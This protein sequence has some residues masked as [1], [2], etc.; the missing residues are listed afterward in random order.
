MIRRFAFALVIF[1]LLALNPLKT[2]ANWVEVKSDNFTFIGDAS[3]RKA[4]K[5]VEEVE[6]YRA[7][8]FKM[9]G[10]DP[11]S[12]I[13]P[14]RIYATKSSREITDITG[15]ENAGGVYVPRRESPL[16]VLNIRGGFSDKSPAKSIALHEYTHHLISRHTNQMY[17]R[18]VNEGMAEYLSTFTATDSG[19][20]RIGLP[21]ETRGRTLATYQWM[22]WD[23]IFGSIRRYP[24]AND[25]SNNTEIGQALF[26]A[27]SW[28]AIH[29]IQS[30]PGLPAVLNTYIQGV[31]QAQDPKAFFTETFNMSPDE[32]GVQLR[33]YFRH[34]RYPGQR[35]T[36]FD[37]SA[38]TEFTV[39]ELSKGEEAFHLGEATR[40]FRDYEDEGQATAREYYDEAEED[41]GPMAQIQA[42]RALIA[43]AAGDT[44]D[45]R[46]FIDRALELDPTDS[47]IL[48]VAA[49]VAMAE[50]LDTDIPSETE[51]MDVIRDL[52]MTA[53]RANPDNV[54]AHFDYVMTYSHTGD[55]PSEQA[56]Q[57]A[58][59]C[60]HQYR[61]AAFFGE[62]MKLATVLLNANEYNYARYHI[63]KASLWSSTPRARR[64]AREMLQR[65]PE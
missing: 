28:L 37:V 22:D 34:N 47:R 9:F 25:G 59:E 16:F 43:I 13:V 7:I 24:F 23:L 33:T 19:T 2:H 18:W 14:V 42:S 32:F 6:Q 5:I 38:T 11:E 53:I 8:L 57:S 65:L 1:T 52:F 58:I 31:P 40:Q 20:V 27:Q 44:A 26:Y 54:E 56:A 61:A 3:E 10:I 29:Y 63:Q 51:D 64:L 62:N 60:T 45:A 50:Y 39:R 12:E 21:N 36:D 48:H 46:T 4:K 55:T 41:G 49:K 35:L 30:T 17:P 15:R